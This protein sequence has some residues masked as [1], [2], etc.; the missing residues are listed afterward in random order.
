MCYVPVVPC[1]CNYMQQSLH[2]FQ[3]PPPKTGL[4]SWNHP[5]VHGTRLE[6]RKSHFLF[7]GHAHIMISF[8]NR[9]DI[10]S[11]IHNTTKAFL[12]LSRFY[13][14]CLAHLDFYLLV[15]VQKI[16]HLFLDLEKFLTLF[17]FWL[18]DFSS[19][20]WTGGRS[21]KAPQA[22]QAGKNSL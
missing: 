6:S 7:N 19:E 2:S 1:M 18:E 21:E 13:W 4:I 3:H 14:K 5:W 11:D 22:G 12:L 16:S 20:L 10:C 17:W 8:I 9:G 15:L